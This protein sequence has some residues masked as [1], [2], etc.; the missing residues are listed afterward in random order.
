MKM[1]FRNIVIR[2][3]GCDCCGDDGFCGSEP[4][5]IVIETDARDISV[6]EHAKIAFAQA[7]LVTTAKSRTKIDV[8]YRGA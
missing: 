7:S 1:T 4:G 2:Y 5:P 8:P 6:M 3:S